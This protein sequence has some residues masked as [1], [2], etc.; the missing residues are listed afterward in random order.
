MKTYLDIE[1][2]IRTLELPLK[3]TRVD[4]KLAWKDQLQIYHPDRFNISNERLRGIA[5]ERT[6]KINNSFDILS[7]L[8]KGDSFECVPQSSNGGTGR[9]NASELLRQNQE[10]QNKITELQRQHREEISTL[11]RKNDATYKELK[12]QHSL[13]ENELRSEHREEISKLKGKYDVTHKEIK[14]Q[15]SLRENELRSEL[16]ERQASLLHEIACLKTT[17]KKHEGKKHRKQRFMEN[18]L[19]FFLEPVKFLLTYIKDIFLKVLG[20]YIGFINRNLPNRSERVAITTVIVFACVISLLLFCAA[21]PWHF[22]FILTCVFVIAGC[23][24]MILE[25]KK[26]NQTIENEKDQNEEIVVS[27]NS[28]NSIEK[29]YTSSLETHSVHEKE[30]L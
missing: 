29:N 11:K 14:D 10:L 7:N 30:R 4:L 26:T 28:G 23:G 5:E 18:F 8:M 25:T 13:R 22:L 15:H 16:W 24:G 27:E 3:F 12:D 20:M 6:K 1:D 9:H 21:I 2:A 17:I 19:H